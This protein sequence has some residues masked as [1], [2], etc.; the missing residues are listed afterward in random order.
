[1]TPTSKR[2]QNKMDVL[3][4]LITSMYTQSVALHPDVHLTVV[5]AAVAHP[6]DGLKCS[7]G[8]QIRAY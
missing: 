5:Q 3:G 4:C 6:G 7:A 8:K 2:S 1:M